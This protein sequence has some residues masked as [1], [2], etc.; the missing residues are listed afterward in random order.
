MTGMH[1]DS[2][3]CG[4]V[5]WRPRV[6]SPIVFAQCDDSVFV[7]TTTD[8]PR[9]MIAACR[10]GREAR[11]AGR[12][13]RP[14]GQDRSRSRAVWRVD[15]SR[16]RWLEKVMTDAKDCD[17]DAVGARI[18]DVLQM[19]KQL[20]VEPAP[21]AITGR[22]STE[23]LPSKV[24]PSCPLMPLLP[25]LPLLPSKVACQPASLPPVPSSLPA[26]LIS[27]NSYFL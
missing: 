16:I 10:Q 24:L 26:A 18:M 9:A 23:F 12:P 5:S 8:S 22:D 20:A 27:N 2:H 4:L 14:A 11:Q 21:P 6:D 3:R 7:D 25:L 19:K 15:D 17:R 1:V 13:A